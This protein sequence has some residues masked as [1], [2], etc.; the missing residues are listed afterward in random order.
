MPGQRLW[1]SQVLLGTPA[2]VLPMHRPSGDLHQRA[3]VWPTT[4]P[5]TAREL[6]AFR[7]GHHQLR[8]THR[9]TKH[10]GGKGVCLNPHRELKAK[11]TDCSQTPL[12]TQIPY[13]EQALL[14]VKKIKIPEKDARGQGEP[15]HG[16]KHRCS[17]APCGHSHRSSR[18]QKRR[19]SG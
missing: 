2:L 10:R 7:I 13:P 6:R 12:D 15:K 1:R 17:P 19:S 8:L 11:L 14:R 5:C 4:L 9:D 18:M 16:L 3:K